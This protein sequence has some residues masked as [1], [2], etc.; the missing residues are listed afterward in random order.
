MRDSNSRMS[1]TFR[2][3]REGSFA[4]H[5]APGRVLILPLPLL[6]D[7]GHKDTGY[8][9]SW[10]S[11]LYNSPA[12]FPK[13]MVPVSCCVAGK[14]HSKKSVQ[15]PSNQGHLTFRHCNATM[16]STKITQKN[17][18]IQLIWGGGKERW[19]TGQDQTPCW[20]CSHMGYLG[21]GVQQHCSPTVPLARCVVCLH[22]CVCY[23]FI[24]LHL[25]AAVWASLQAL[26]LGSCCQRWV[27]GWGCQ[28]SYYKWRCVIFITLLQMG[29]SLQKSETRK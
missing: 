3:P 8:K 2:A 22:F 16:S 18:T 6:M 14:C 9:S 4:K 20:P 10:R 15:R 28:S 23:T 5:L 13:T 25:W 17:F 21:V 11:W 29:F 12:K 19:P 26:A 1:V 27:W 24:T 7:Q